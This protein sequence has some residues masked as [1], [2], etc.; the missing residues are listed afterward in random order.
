MSLQLGTPVQAPETLEGWY[1]LHQVFT[2]D[3]GAHV[4]GGDARSESTQV[5]PSLAADADGWSA[6]ARLIGS[7]HDVLAVHLRPT[8]DEIGDVGRQTRCWANDQRLSLDYS[9]LSVT[10]A[11]LYHLTAQSPARPRA[12]SRETRRPRRCGK[13]LARAR[14]RSVRTR[15]CKR[16]CSRAIPRTCRTSASTR[17]PSAVR[18]AKLVM[19][20]A[21]RTEPAH[22]G[23]RP[24]WTA[25]RGA[26]VQI[27]TGAIGFEAWEWGVTLFAAD[28]L[29]FKKLVTD[30]RF[31]EVSAKYA[32]FGEFFVGKLTS[33]A[34]LLRS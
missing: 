24:D 22:A 11:G 31:D 8:L 29:D 33:P 14:R 10:E 20:I 7:S 5:L 13:Q 15:T 12:R 25:L 30:M 18:R 17:C 1:A 28:P 4:S 23:P 19:P 27:I 9:F 32:E 21:R 34:E 26:V 6:Y 3:A 16:G 2:H